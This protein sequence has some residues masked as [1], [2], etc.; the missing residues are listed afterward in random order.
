M[1]VADARTQAFTLKRGLCETCQMQVFLSRSAQDHI[2]AGAKVICTHCCPDPSPADAI[3]AF[4]DVQKELISE[5]LNE[6]FERC[7]QERRRN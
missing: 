7:E 2:N 3:W 5:Q 4:L 6:T 1:R